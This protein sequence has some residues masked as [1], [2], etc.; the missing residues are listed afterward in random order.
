MWL[1]ALWFESHVS[2][3]R[4]IENFDICMYEGPSISGTD[5]F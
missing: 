3:T 2:N 1:V 5:E 4:I